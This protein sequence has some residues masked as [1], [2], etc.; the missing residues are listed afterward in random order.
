MIGLVLWGDLHGLAE[1]LDTAED[2]AIF[3]A[4]EADLWG[5]IAG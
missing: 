4:I 5:A 1:R 2:L 3:R